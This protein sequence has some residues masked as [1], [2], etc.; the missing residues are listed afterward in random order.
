MNAIKTWAMRHVQTAI[1]TLGR[2]SHQWLPTSFMVLVIGIALA[3][4]ACLQVVLLNARL[5]G[6]DFNRAIEISVYFKVGASKAQ[7][8]QAAEFVRKRGDVADVRLITAD[9]ALIEFR[10]R[11]GFGDALTALTDNP[12]PHALVIRPNLTASAM[13]LDK[14]V[15]ELRDVPNV[16]VVQLDSAW[17]ERF[18]AIV[19]ALRRATIVI[20]TLLGLGVIVIVGS[21]IRSDIQAH[22]EEIEVTKLVGGSDAFVRRPFLYT[23]IWFGLAGGVLA[24]VVTYV[25]VGLLGAPV[26]R[27]ALLY[28]SNFEMMSLRGQN[29]LTILGLAVGLG[30]IGSYVAA[31][32]HLRA[33]EPK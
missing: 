18:N 19:D 8:E 27:I 6:G 32:R 33:I 23:G 10:K 2:L 15:N 25:V 20:G 17:V 31:T 5:A 4:P 29:A 24:L 30:W 14:L 21:A 3:L 13:Q 28:G 16:E 9:D 12:L 26:K 7:A 1:G 22:R 11:S